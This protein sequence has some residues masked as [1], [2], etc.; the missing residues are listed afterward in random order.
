MKLIKKDSHWLYALPIYLL[1]NSLRHQIANVIAVLLTGG[2]LTRFTLLPDFS[3]AGWLRFSN[4]QWV[5]GEEWLILAAP[6][7]ADLITFVVFF[8]LLQRKV[9]QK[10]WLFINLLILGLLSP[11][12][13]SAYDYFSTVFV[14][15]DVSRIIS[16]MPYEELVHL[17]FVLTLSFYVMAIQYLLQ[18]SAT[19]RFFLLKEMEERQRVKRQKRQKAKNGVEL[20]KKEHNSK[21]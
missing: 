14:A 2:R 3:P 10:R 8:L 12:F 11:V 17:Y 21:A 4:I 16:H 7:V 6:Y 18:N 20:N 9:V 19:A 1:I 13:N 15:T 5:G